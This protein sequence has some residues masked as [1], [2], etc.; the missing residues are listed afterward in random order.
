MKKCLIIGN[1]KAPEKKT[2]LFLMKKGYDTIICADGGLHHAHK[3]KLIPNYIIGDF[4]SV[5]GNLLEEYRG[6]SKIIQIKRQNDTDI[7]KCLKYAV[8]QKFTNAILLSVTGDRLDHSFCN[9]GIVLKFHDEINARIISETSLLSVYEKHAIIATKKGEYISLYAFDSKTKITSKG[10]KYPLFNT[11]LPF[12]IREST[13]NVAVADEVY[14]I[15]KSGKIFVIRDFE[16]MR[17]YDL[18]S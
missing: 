15:I 16:T 1:G 3:L 7:E 10:L 6:K 14:L 2:I 17:K 13:S 4:D 5:D 11:Q 9:L 18:F 8:K 12:G